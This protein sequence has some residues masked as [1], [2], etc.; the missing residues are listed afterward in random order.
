[1]CP[2]FSPRG[3]FGVGVME[4]GLNQWFAVVA[5]FRRKGLVRVEIH[6]NPPWA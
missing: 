5:L 2:R 6:K 1:M 3:S 4:F